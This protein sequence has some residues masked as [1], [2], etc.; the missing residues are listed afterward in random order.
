MDQFAAMTGAITAEQNGHYKA[1]KAFGPIEYEAFAI[2]RAR[3]AAFRAELSYR[4]CVQPE[5]V[6]S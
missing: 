2:P 6:Q 3:R 1:T 4:G 5:P